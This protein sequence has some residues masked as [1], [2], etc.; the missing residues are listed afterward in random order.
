M[1]TNKILKNL[2]MDKKI[3]LSD[4]KGTLFISDI[5][6]LLIVSVL[7]ISITITVMDLS[8]EKI[9]SSVERSN[10]ERKS[11]EV[12]DNLIKNPGS[13]DNW[14]Y[15]KNWVNT[16][17]GLAEKN[18]TISFNKLLSLKKFYAKL[19]DEKIFQNEIKSS[20][21]I[22]SLNSKTLSM[23]FGD[24]EENLHHV[25]N[26]VSAKRLVKCDFLT[27]FKILDFKETKSSCINPNHHEDTWICKS[28]TIKKKDLALM[29]YYL[30]FSD[31]STG[32]NSH[33][34]IN[35][36]KDIVENEHLI[37]TDS[38]RIN[39]ILED[40]IGNSIQMNFWIHLKL[41]NKTNN[42]D[43]CLVAIPNDFNSNEIL[44]K[45]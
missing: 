41:S 10:L 13:P 25:S 16:I 21:T 18:K 44:V 7:V 14:D 6:I 8:T 19:V 29:D 5:F 42:I 35:N 1:N 45:V 28:F 43:G 31:E 9:L 36:P 26:V 33:W 4:R 3:L 12:L 15:Q 39:S 34:S 23:K 40:Q 30:L 22:Y 32:T 11:A 17:P 38:Y 24:N 37:N 2:K 20:M 27:R